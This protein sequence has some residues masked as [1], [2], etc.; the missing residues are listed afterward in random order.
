MEKVTGVIALAFAAIAMAV[1]AGPAVAQVPSDLQNP[2]IEISYV[3]PRNPAFQPIHDRLRERKVLEQLKAFLAPLRLDRM[4]EV[5][6]DECGSP[7]AHYKPG[8]GAVTVCYEYVGLIGSLAPELSSK[9]VLKIG[10]KPFTREDALVGAFVHVALH[11][12]ARA[13]FDVHQIPIW[14]RVEHAA[15]R[16]AGFIMLQFGESVSYRTFVGASWMLAQA[17]MGSTGVPQGDFYAV[18]GLDVETVQRFFNVMCIAIGGD[19]KRFEFLRKSLPAARADRCRREFLQLERSFTDTIMPYV[20]RDLLR[21]V[22]AI[23]WLKS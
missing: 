4:I 15:D 19:P 14:G 2:Q 1:Q 6:I 7:Y 21:R 13:V 12:V 10:N 9:T 11:E 3:V 8:S 5:K 22:R 18:R 16:T 23:E 20:D 17:G